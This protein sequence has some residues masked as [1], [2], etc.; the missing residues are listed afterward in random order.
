MQILPRLQGS[1][2]FQAVAF[3]RK[4]AV[5]SR[6]VADAP[7][8]VAAPPRLGRASG[9]GADW[10]RD[11]AF[12]LAYVAQGEVDIYA[13]RRRA[14]CPAGTFA[15]LFSRAWRAPVN[16]PHWFD[17]AGRK[18][19]SRFFWLVLRPGMIVS[20][21]CRLQDGAV[22]ET[23]ALYIPDSRLHSLVPQ[24][25]AECGE[26]ANPDVSCRL[27][28]LFFDRVRR[29]LREDSF[30]ITRPMQEDSISGDVTQS[31]GE[32][33][34]RYVEANLKEKLTLESVARAIFSTRTRVA[35]DFKAHTG[36]PLGAYLQHR[37]LEQAR[38]FLTTTTD[39]IATIARRS[40]FSDADY[41]SAT[42]RR[43]EGMT[44]SEYRER[45]AS[46]TANDE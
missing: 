42:F 19:E 40:G 41:F 15:L 37:R 22:H 16:G 11:D 36:M 26:A 23:K 29:K 6:P 38:Q 4:C 24:L 2:P 8:L 32:K 1:E 9:I 21:A 44:P 5:V 39:S 14:I 43:G 33:A 45:A 28:W 27:L 12:I 34:Q 7:A 10:Q 20:H 31:V 46:R 30:L 35:R 25:S 13:G 3:G 17:V 18:G